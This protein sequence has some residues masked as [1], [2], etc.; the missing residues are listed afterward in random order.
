VSKGL[1]KIEFYINYFE[2]RGLESLDTIYNFSAKYNY[3]SVKVFIVG[4][5]GVAHAAKLVKTNNGYEIR[6]RKPKIEDEQMLKIRK[7]IL[8]IEFEP[9]E[10]YENLK[11]VI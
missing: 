7:K 5:R 6:L 8:E 3:D 10:Q 2:D 4:I 9:Y 1:A 11:I